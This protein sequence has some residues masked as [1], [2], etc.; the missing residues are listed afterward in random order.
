MTFRQA[1]PYERDIIFR[2]GYK[3]WSKNRTF[4]QYCTDNA[5]EDSYGTRYLLDI[6]GRIVSSLILLRLGD[7]GGR[8]VRGIGS[9]L[10]PKV[11]SGKGYATELMKNT[12]KTALNEASCILLF[13]DISPDFYKR[14]G[15]RILPAGL[16]KCPKSTCMAYCS[17][18]CWDELVSGSSYALPDYF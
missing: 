5:R 13:S 2:E 6:D 17:E 1:Q 10:T 16:Q 7:V 15:F 12:V 8:K 14:F 18:E 9:V 4:E 3:V 11:E